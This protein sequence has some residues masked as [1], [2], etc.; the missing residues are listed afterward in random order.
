MMPVI[1]TP[2]EGDAI[3]NFSELFRKPAGCFLNIND[4]ERIYD[5]MAEWGNPEDI[6]YVVVSGSYS[7]SAVKYISNLVLD[8]EE[9]LGI[10]DQ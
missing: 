10:G 3:Q 8:G 2:T 1:Y 5:D 9:I 6:D 7:L 4:G